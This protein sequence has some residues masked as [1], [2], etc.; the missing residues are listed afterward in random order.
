MKVETFMLCDAASETEGKL[1]V[2][3]GFDTIL[4]SGVPVTHS[5]CAVALRT[6][7]SRIEEGDHTL[8]VNFIDE[9]GIEVL[10]K[11][12]GNLEVRLTDGTDSAASNIILDINGLKLPRFGRYAIDLAIDGRQ[13]AT[14]PLYVKQ[15]PSVTKEN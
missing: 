4:T 8:R 13:E 2:Q 6:R 1:N 9:D 14:I 5:F 15:K 10:P 11:I 12:E 3:G 7:F